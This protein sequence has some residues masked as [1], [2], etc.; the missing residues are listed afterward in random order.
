MWF[1]YVSEGAFFLLIARRKCAQKK[2]FKREFASCRKL[3]TWTKTNQIKPDGW[4][5]GEFFVITDP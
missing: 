3:T 2:P 4:E 5:S 1:M